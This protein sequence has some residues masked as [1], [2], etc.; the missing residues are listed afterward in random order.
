MGVTLA[1]SYISTKLLFFS[2]TFSNSLCARGPKGSYEGDPIDISK[3]FQ[4]DNRAAQTY[5]SKSEPQA[6]EKIPS[7]Y[8]D[9]D[10]CNLPKN[11]GAICRGSIPS[12]FYDIESKKCL[13]SD[14]ED[15]MEIRTD[16]N[17]RKSVKKHVYTTEMKV[18]TELLMR[19]LNFTP[20]KQKPNKP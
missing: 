19:K 10:I 16:L 4:L 5:E 11:E 8:G 6:F 20:I 9:E 1:M 3:I 12:W 17:Q 2:S 7:T 18:F 14:A 13:V 15:V